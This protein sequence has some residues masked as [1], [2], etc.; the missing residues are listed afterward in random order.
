MFNNNTKN[1][2]I[3]N[4]DEATNTYIVCLALSI[5]DEYG[6]EVTYGTDIKSDYRPGDTDSIRNCVFNL[7]NKAERIKE[8]ITTIKSIFGDSRFSFKLQFIRPNKSIVDQISID[9][10]ELQTIMDIRNKFQLI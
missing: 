5:I 9:N 4:H 2:E 10:S 3:E 7:S 8:V 6:M 1:N